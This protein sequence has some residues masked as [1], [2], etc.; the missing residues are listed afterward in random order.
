MG[1][2][3]GGG[4]SS[5]GEYRVGAPALTFRSASIQLRFDIDIVLTSVCSY[6][7]RPYTDVNC[8]RCPK[9]RPGIWF[10]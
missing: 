5:T 8:G 10:V 1:I 4:V 9:L 3:L 7:N 2:R 6:V